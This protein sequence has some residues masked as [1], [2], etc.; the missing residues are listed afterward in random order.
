[1][2]GL[3]ARTV[4]QNILG[5]TQILECRLGGLHAVSVISEVTRARFRSTVF[6][7]LSPEKIS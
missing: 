3:R 2:F 4:G 5:R 6:T 7:R 1:M